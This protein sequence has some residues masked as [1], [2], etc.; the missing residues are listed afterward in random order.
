MAVRDV[1][2]ELHVSQSELARRVNFAVTREA[3]NRVE[4]GHAGLSWQLAVKIAVGLV[5]QPTRDR[6]LDLAE[7]LMI[8]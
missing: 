6:V 2:E 1:R 5:D 3:L 4:N 8:R 7:K